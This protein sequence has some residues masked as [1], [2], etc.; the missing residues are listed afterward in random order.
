MYNKKE[1]V[2]EHSHMSISSLS[3]NLW[4]NFIH[5]FNSSG[6]VKKFQTIPMCRFHEKIIFLL[7]PNEEISPFFRLHMETFSYFLRWFYILILTFFQV[8]K[9]NRSPK[10]DPQMLKQ[11]A[12]IVILR[13]VPSFTQQIRAGQSNIEK[14]LNK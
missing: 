10:N 3:E 14:H 2:S 5:V 13:H 8:C 12:G 6:I 9:Q 4:L 7:C 1:H 11:R